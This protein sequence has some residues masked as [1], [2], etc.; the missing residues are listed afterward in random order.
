MQVYWITIETDQCHCKEWTVVTDLEANVSI[1]PDPE[2]TDRCRFPG[3]GTG[4]LLESSNCQCRVDLG[5]LR[6]GPTRNET[7]GRRRLDN[8]DR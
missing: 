2:L 3:K 7:R 1:V 6:F 8:S 5:D 4:S